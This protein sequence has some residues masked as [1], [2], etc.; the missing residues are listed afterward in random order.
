MSDA[1]AL[2]KAGDQLIRKGEVE[3]G[4]AKLR[5]AVAADDSHLLA[6]L[7]LSRQL[8]LLGQHEDA[9]KHG[10]RAC[11]ID[12]SDPIHFTVLSVTY[13]RA[14]AAT[15]NMQF[16]QLAEDARDRAQALGQQQR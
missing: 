13:Q 15:G 12:P 11:Q 9:V 2:Y 3:P 14:L 7:T 5:E 6:H 10:E 16:M 4:V 1:E 8:S